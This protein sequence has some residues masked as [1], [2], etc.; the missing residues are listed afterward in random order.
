VCNQGFTRH[1]NLKVHMYKSH[2]KEYLENNFSSEELESLMRPPPGSNTSKPTPSPRKIKDDEIM[3]AGSPTGVLPIS[4]PLTPKLSPK[5]ISSSITLTPRSQPSSPETSSSGAVTPVQAYNQVSPPSLRLPAVLNMTVSHLAVSPLKRGRPGPA[6]LTKPRHYFESEASLVT[7]LCQ[8]CED[9][10]LQRADLHDHL[11][12]EHGISLLACPACQDRFLEPADLAQHLTSVHGHTHGE[13]APPV[14]AAAQQHQLKDVELAAAARRRPGPASRTNAPRENRTSS[15]VSSSNLPGHL[16]GQYGDLPGYPCSQCGKILMHKQS[17]VSHMRVIHGDYYGGNKWRGSSVVDMVLGGEDNNNSSSSSQEEG[18]ELIS[19]NKKQH[20]DDDDQPRHQQMKAQLTATLKRIAQHNGFSPNYADFSPKLPC[21]FCQQ[22]YS[23]QAAL[24][25]H[26]RL[27]HPYLN[28]QPAVRLKDTSAEHEEPDTKRIRLDYSK[29]TVLNTIDHLLLPSSQSVPFLSAAHHA[30]HFSANGYDEPLDLACRPVSVS[31]DPE[32]DRADFFA[33]D[34]NNNSSCHS[35]NN[36]LQVVQVNHR[37]CP[38]PPCSPLNLHVSRPATSSPT[39]PPPPA[40]AASDPALQESPPAAAPGAA[41]GST[42]PA[43]KVQ[44]YLVKQNHATADEH[45]RKKFL[46]PVCKCQLSWKT[47]LSVHL[48]THSGERPF[49]CVLCLNRFRQKAHLYKHFRCSHGHKVAPFQCLFC[50]ESFSR[51]P[52]DLYNHITEVHKKET[53]E[54]QRSNSNNNINNN[55]TILRPG[56]EEEEEVGNAEERPQ[57][58]PLALVTAPTPPSDTPPR[59]KS[60]EAS[61]T[62]LEEDEEDV[63]DEETEDDDDEADSEDNQSQPQQQTVVRDR[64]DD[65]RYEPI[66]EEFLFEGEMIKPCYCVLPF[67]TDEEV[68]AITRRSISVSHTLDMWQMIFFMRNTGTA[69][70]TFAKLSS[71]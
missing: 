63:E 58:A 55:G 71:T 10:F 23:S 20:E 27:Q 47:N 70:H 7:L 64:E 35:S 41:V 46:C 68:E 28:R 11:S 60:P 17:Y 67:V 56:E 13:G 69:Y 32:A 49:Q 2:G 24:E 66:T 38:S 34:S 59:Q 5:Q 3:I 19:T 4:P 1:Y 48:R 29:G 53:D 33:H 43:P 30:Q 42:P 14:Q 51:S 44:E 21:E 40:V 22:A 6:S 26:V 39:P 52:N 31:I 45:G 9:K 16:A 62:Q 50:P 54:M 37:P 57:S 8:L 18:K 25:D 65:M 61:V 36:L 12:R 15:A